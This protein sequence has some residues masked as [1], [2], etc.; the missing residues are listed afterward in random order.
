MRFIPTGRTLVT[1]LVLLLITAAAY[2][3]SLMLQSKP[4]QIEAVFESAVGLYPGNDVQVLGVPVGRVTA[5][6]PEDGAVRVTMELESEHSAAADTAA[7]IVA[8]TLVSD[9]FVQLTKPYV[10]GPTIEAGTVIAQERT[11]V[12][13]EIDEL[14]GSLNDLGRTLGPEGANRNGALSRFLDVAAANLDGQG[15]EINTMLAE[16]GKAT[17]TLERS[18]DQFFQTLANLQRFNDMLVR[19][20]RAVADVNRRFAAV[21]GYLADDREELALAVRNLADAL[22]VLDDFIRE[23]RGHLKASVEQ[24]KGPTKVLADQ[25]EALE[26]SIRMA[27]LVLQNFL[28]A[29]NA[30]HGTL[31]GRGNLNELTLWARDGLTNTTSDDAPPT[32]LPSDAGSPS[33]SPSESTSAGV[34]P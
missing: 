27:P 2:G 30:P 13:V 26:E 25:Q 6:E 14:Y 15:K 18:D 17:A 21:T 32:L 9:R 33:G 12:P 28:R 7:V 16:F 23:N 4:V 34:Q 22:A 1:A 11:A 24:M 8:P 20:D 3:G 5:V 29:Y 19:N 31:D 10:D